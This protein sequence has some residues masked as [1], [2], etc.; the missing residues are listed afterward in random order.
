MCDILRGGRSALC[1]PK[2][3]QGGI[4]W[5]QGFDNTHF[6]EDQD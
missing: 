6:M 3:Q 2:E 5:E 1:Y 4:L